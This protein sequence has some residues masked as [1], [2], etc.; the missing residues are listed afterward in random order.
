[1]V[2]AVYPGTFDPLTRGHQDIVRRA[3]G[4]FEHIVVGIADSDAKR[5][6][7]NIEERVA[8]AKEVLAEYP[9]VEVRRFSGLLVNFV[10]SCQAHVVIRGL[11]AVSDFEYEFQLA[12]MNRHLMPE[13]ETIFMTP[14]DQYQ[15]VSG[16]LVREI[17]VLGGDVSQ[18]VPPS[19]SGWIDRK[20][21]Q[22]G[23]KPKPRP[24]AG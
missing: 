23:A 1:M 8:I 5:P 22:M 4:L 21:A 18:F 11:R 20:L 9:N 15:F 24:D 16:T 10:R 17:A 2:T 12:G 3:A 14:T 6:I 19:V 13:I 7:F